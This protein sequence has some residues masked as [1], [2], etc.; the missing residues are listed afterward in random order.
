MFL[1]ASSTACKIIWDWRRISGSRTTATLD[2]VVAKEQAELG[3]TGSI[4]SSSVLR[5]KTLHGPSWA[6]VFDAWRPRPCEP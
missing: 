2:T 4:V 1:D 3:E 5:G 6:A